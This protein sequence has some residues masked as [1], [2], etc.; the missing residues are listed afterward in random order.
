MHKF[1][2]KWTF[3][4]TTFTKDRG[5]VFSCFPGG[6]GSSMGYKLAGFDI[7]GF[8]EIDKKMAENYLAN[9]EV[10]YPFIEG[11]QDLNRRKNLPKALYNLD[12]LDGSPPCST[13]SMAG[14]R[15]KNWGKL[16]KFR[17][18]QKK[19][20]LDEL[21][22]EFIKLAKKLQPKI[23]ISENVRGILIG[24]AM[25]YKHNY[26]NAII[27]GFDKAGY[28]TNFYLF[29]SSKMGVPQKRQRVF[30]VSVR[31]DLVSPFLFPDGFFNKKL[32][33]DLEFNESPILF[34]T[35]RG[36]HGVETEADRQKL[37]KYKIKSDTCIGDINER[38]FNKLSGFTAMLVKDTE[39]CPTITASDIHWRWYDDLKFSDYDYTI[40]GTFPLDYQFKGNVKYIIGMSVPPIMM[41]QVV[42][43][44]YEQILLKINNETNQGN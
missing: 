12:I 41:A 30:F 31:N 2:Y 11:I 23:V 29:N 15:D 40:C 42:S 6:G 35:V 19:Q 7:I 22:F 18:G 1:P 26:V 32:N 33:I 5:T 3:E 17:E 13:F 20:I 9:M 10:K 38:L 34:G 43:R 4:N 14:K 36:K 8:C 16:K 44:I 21:F 37:L 28:H 27:K 25:S 39:V 24:K